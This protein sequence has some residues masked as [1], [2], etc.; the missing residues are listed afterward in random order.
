MKEK[1]EDHIKKLKDEFKELGEQ[2]GQD[3]VEKLE[4]K[5]DELEK[6]IDEKIAKANEVAKNSTAEEGNKLETSLKAEI[7]AKTE[8]YN[9]TLGEMQSRID[10]METKAGRL[11]QFNAS[12]DL[13]TTLKSAL[14]NSEGYK[15]FK[16]GNADKV[17]IDLKGIDVLKAGD[18]TTGNSYTGEIIAPTRVPGFVFDPDRSTHIRNFIALGQTDS[19]SIVYN[20]ETA[21]DDG[22]GTAAEGSALGQ[23]DADFT[24]VTESVQKVGTFLTVTDEMMNDTPGLSSYLTARFSRKVMLEED[25]QI[26]HGDG[27]GNNLTG[28]SVDATAYTDELGDADVT[29]FD[30]LG[31]AIKQAQVSEY[32]PNV[33]LV[34][35]TDWWLM[36]ITKDDNGNY[37]VPSVY[38]GAPLVVGGVPVIANTAVTSDEFFVGDFRLGAQLWERQ[39]VT[40]EFSNSH[41]TNF[42]ELQTTIRIYERIALAIYRP[43]AFR[44]GDFSNALALG[45]A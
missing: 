41:S 12:V 14:E 16:E 28:I 4:K 27:T 9:K 7:A 30:V 20:Q 45:S 23:S 31:F 34:H 1:D 19:D 43:N 44:Y 25:D 32:T 11:E 37:L 35:P 2:I 42:T 40:M 22:T 18:M 8:E 3:T 21:I 10:A 15:R 17:S 33:I 24:K 38:S 13:R 39:A 6:S 36:A 5:A 29:R 26:L